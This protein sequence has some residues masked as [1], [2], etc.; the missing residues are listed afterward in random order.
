L[1][2]RRS[3]LRTIA[4]GIVCLVAL[5]YTMGCGGIGPTSVT[6]TG[7]YPFTVTAVSS[8]GTT[9]SISMSLTITVDP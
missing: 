1:F 9:H 3:S 8:G 6:P 2:R 5:G 7:T 4:L